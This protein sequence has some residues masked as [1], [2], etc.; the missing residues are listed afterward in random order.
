MPGA[1]SHHRVRRDHPRRTHR[2]ARAGASVALVA[3]VEPLLVVVP[4]LVAAAA[5]RLARVEPDSWELEVLPEAPAKVAR[6]AAAARTP[7][8]QRRQAPG[9][10]PPA[11]S[12]EW[13]PSAVAS[14]GLLRSLVR[15]G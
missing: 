11:T 8:A 10:M 9:S 3:L 5:V 6:R 12:P 1:M 2:E 4:L 15:S 14:V 7:A 13:H